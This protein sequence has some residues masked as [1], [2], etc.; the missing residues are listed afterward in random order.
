MAQ[1]K[2]EL[3]HEK[4]SYQ[5]LSLGFL[6]SHNG[7]TM[8]GIIASLNAGLLK[9]IV[10]VVISN[11]SSSN[12]LK[13]ARSSKIPAFHISE[14]KYTTPE[15]TDM[16]IRNCLISHK[17]NLVIMSGYMKKVGKF[18]IAAFS[19]RILNV[20]PSLLP[21]HTGLWGDSVHQAVL[22]SKDKVT[23][24]TIHIADIHYDHGPVLWQSEVPVLKDDT[25]E[26]LKSRV[27]KEEIN[28]FTILL[29]KIQVGEISL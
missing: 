1:N 6:A 7:T 21:R 14:K 12:A 27:Q 18:T 2:S 3:G 5:P 11:N 9:G 13:F 4:L 22:S 8:Q 20:H 23:G 24:V 29:Q 10:K 16:A 25:V 28:A 19:N 17:V 15:K 26:T